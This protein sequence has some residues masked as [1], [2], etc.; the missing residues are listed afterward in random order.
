[1]SG[2]FIYF[3]GKKPIAT[4]PKHIYYI[5][6]SAVCET[7]VKFLFHPYVFYYVYIEDVSGRASGERIN[8][9]G[10]TYNVIIVFLTH[11]A[12]ITL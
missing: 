1:M 10:S 6:S 12:A 4:G 5:T 8:T 3:G 7:L 9:R 2:L 11:Y